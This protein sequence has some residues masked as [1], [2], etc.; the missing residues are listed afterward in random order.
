VGRAVAEPHVAPVFTANLT[1]DILAM[2]LKSLFGNHTITFPYV[3][4]GDLSNMETL[5]K[6]PVAR[7]PVYAVDT[8]EKVPIIRYDFVSTEPTASVTEMKYSPLVFMRLLVNVVPV[9]V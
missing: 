6:R 8:L 7:V 2:I 5:P 4:P 1:S 3:S 9:C